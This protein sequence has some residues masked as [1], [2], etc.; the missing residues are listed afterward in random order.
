MKYRDGQERGEFPLG[1]EE[2][3]G[4]GIVEK[5]DSENM[6]EEAP[7]SIPS[8]E[9]LAKKA[10][11][12]LR[13]QFARDWQPADWEDMSQEAVLKV[14]LAVE[15]KKFDPSRFTNAWFKTVVHRVAVDHYRKLHGRHGE[16]IEVTLLNE[17]EGTLPDELV[18]EDEQVGSALTRLSVNDLLKMTS[19]LLPN[20]RVV[21]HLTYW[22][23]LKSDEIA[24]VLGCAA[25]TVRTWHQAALN[26]LRAHI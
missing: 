4:N 15:K 1:M 22:H 6:E 8:W 11:D 21:L 20:E 14:S 12:L 18:S 10:K 23:G 7:A 2:E 13:Y 5:S 19:E 3:G 16:R 24:E 9:N 17:T 26:K 25:A